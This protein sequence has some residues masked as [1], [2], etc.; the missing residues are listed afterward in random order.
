MFREYTPHPKPFC[1]DFPFESLSLPIRVRTSFTGENIKFPTNSVKP[2]VLTAM[3]EHLL[4]TTYWSTEQ[5][6]W[7]LCWKQSVIAIAGCT[8]QEGQ[9]WLQLPLSWQSWDFNQTTLPG[10]HLREDCVFRA[11]SHSRSALSLDPVQP[12]YPSLCP[13]P[14]PLL[15]EEHLPVHLQG[16]C[17]GERAGRG[18]EISRRN[19]SHTE[20]VSMLPL[21]T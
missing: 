11:T 6:K 4:Y 10:S 16:E 20:W 5:E 13:P 1:L 21:M 12:P 3:F 19:I 8:E 9:Q 14:P 15:A 17:V 2:W 7:R 18:R